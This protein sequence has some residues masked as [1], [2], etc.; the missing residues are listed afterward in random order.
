MRFGDTI[1][2]CKKKQDKVEE[3]EAPK[4]IVLRRNHFSLMTS[5]GLMDTLIYGKDIDKTYI[6]FVPIKEWGA[7]Y[8]KEG[9]KFYIDYATPK[10]HEENGKSANAFIQSVSYQNL[11]IKLVIRRKV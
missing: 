7:E 4:T 9:D 2:Y 1:Y 5:K 8:F 3:Y 10:E 11:F 6:A